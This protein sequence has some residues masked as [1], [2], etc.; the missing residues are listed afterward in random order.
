VKVVGGLKKLHE[1]ELHD[2]CSSP[3]IR[4]RWV[5]QVARTGDM[6]DAYKMLIGKSE[7]KN[8]LGNQGIDGIIILTRILKKYV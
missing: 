3:N 8:H 6:T 2:M 5:G 7:G 4:M 1:E